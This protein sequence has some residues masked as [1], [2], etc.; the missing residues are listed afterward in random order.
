MS[1]QSVVIEVTPSRLELAVVRRGVTIGARALRHDGVNWDRDW[2]EAL[3]R[4][5]PAF[6]GMV[7]DLGCR[8]ARA[9]VVYQG[10]G[11]VT[12][13]CSCPTSSAAGDARRA[14]ELALTGL[15]EFS[16]EGNPF[17]VVAIARDAPGGG[18]GPITQ[19]HSLAVAD[20]DSRAAAVATW[21]E[22][23]GL[24]LAG[25]TPLDAAAHC[26]AALNC[27]EAGPRSGVGA[28]LWV[29]EHTSALA[30]GRAGNL[31]F[32]RLIPLGTES[33]VDAIARPLRA[34]SSDAPPV[35]L[36]RAALRA[37]LA[38]VGVPASASAIP[39]HPELSGASLVSLLQPVIQRLSIEA[40]QSV[41]FGVVEAD[42]QHVTL[43]LTG[44]GARLPN[45][46][47]MLSTQCG[48]ALYTGHDAATAATGSTITSGAIAA[49]LSCAH[50]V[51]LILPARERHRVLATR[52]RRAL[53]YGAAAAAVLV[54][55]DAV[56]TRAVLV[57]QSA[58]LALIERQSPADL[59]FEQSG[60]RILND[61]SELG[62]IERRIRASVG[63]SPD[64]PAVMRM[65]GRTTPPAI[66]ISS[67]EMTRSAGGARILV[68]AS[69]RIDAGGNAAEAIRSYL[70]QLGSIPLFSGVKLGT[71]QR[72]TVDGHESQNFDFTLAAVALPLAT[73]SGAPANAEVASSTPKERP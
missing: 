57:A 21:V 29:G 60:D 15:A 20:T 66:R 63:E 52:A 11:S 24:R 9:T 42:R 8:G 44:P 69:T 58:T 35:S 67:M 59:S 53:W 41:R 13:V 27:L 68:R 54:A 36:D 37:V 64:W 17:E 40:K 19:S 18:T 22:A 30:V 4:L 39:G 2:P 46:A 38:Q 70:G 47:A 56:A 55:S 34:R 62:A 33:L 32:V 5:G 49:Y 43:R 1:E 48:F 51:P 6:A 7:E 14:A 16:L 23:A 12:T 72:G 28:V 31:R 3:D 10:P 71:C 26:D 50:R 65:I 25:I 61:R 45:L 73:P